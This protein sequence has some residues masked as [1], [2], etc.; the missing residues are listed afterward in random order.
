MVTS[1][2]LE[3]LRT[4]IILS[5]QGTSLSKKMLIHL[6]LNSG[7]IHYDSALLT[8]VSSEDGYTPDEIHTAIAGITAMH[9]IAHTTHL[10]FILEAMGTEFRFKHDVRICD[11]E[12]V[13][14]YLWLGHPMTNSLS[15]PRSSP[16]KEELE[17]VSLSLNEKPFSR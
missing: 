16:S 6:L 8:V 12:G 11:D 10:D 9:D 4:L 3:A 5:K 2:Q 17:K 14:L 13:S 15:L 7:R 1:N